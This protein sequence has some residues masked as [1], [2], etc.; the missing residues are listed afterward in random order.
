MVSFWGQYGK[1]HRGGVGE[2]FVRR[3][4]GS[5]T[6]KQRSYLEKRNIQTVR[7]KKKRGGVSLLFF[8]GEKWGN[9]RIIRENA[10]GGRREKVF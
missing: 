8:R 2:K 3:G 6:N 10:G 7:E 1:K 5:R 4:G 9:Q